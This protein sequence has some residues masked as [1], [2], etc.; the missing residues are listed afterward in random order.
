MD[1]DKRLRLVGIRV[2]PL[3]AMANRAGKREREARKRHKRGG[4]GTMFVTPTGREWLT[5][6]L[7]HRKTFAVLSSSAVG[8][9]Q[10]RGHS[11]AAVPVDDSRKP[12]KT[13]V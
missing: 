6:K 13:D 3:K 10:A 4:I 1:V 12:V 2:N 8:F 9:I 7:G 11:V 5:L